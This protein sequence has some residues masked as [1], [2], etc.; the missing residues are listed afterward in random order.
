MLTDTHAHLFWDSFSEDLPEV[1]KRAKEAGITTIFNVGTDLDSSQLALNQLPHL[2]SLARHPKHRLDRVSSNTSGLVSGSSISFYSTIGIHPH[3]AFKYDTPKKLEDAIQKLESIYHQNP[4]KIIGVGECGLDFFFGLNPD[5]IPSD[6]SED[7]LKD[8]QFKLFQ[9]QID[10][11]KKLDLP[12]IVHVRDDRSKNP[13][14]TECW[15][16]AVEMTGSYKGIYHCYSG[17]PNTTSQILN[18][19][20]LIS[21][22]A[23]ITYP[24]NDYLRQVAKDL[25]LERICLE[26]DS[27]FLPPQSLR[28]KRNEPQTVKEIAELIAELKGIPL[29]KVA[30]I[31]TQ[32]IK[33]LFK[34]S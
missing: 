5:W 1:L 17:L 4:Q 8:F 19:N 26:T 24:K 10:L 25:P 21:F 11:A 23:P 31:T 28:G 9:A 32:N 7:Q 6:Y 12:L 33:T 18:T 22:A 16:M 15:T 3:D 30:Q 27:P 29:E 2:E 14:N 20:F 13:Q 34:L